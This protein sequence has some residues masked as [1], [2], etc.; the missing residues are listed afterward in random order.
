MDSHQLKHSAR[1][2]IWTVPWY[3]ASILVVCR[4][5]NSGVASFELTLDAICRRVWMMTSNSPNTQ[6]LSPHKSQI[7]EG[8]VRSECSSLSMCSES[9]RFS[10]DK[11]L[12]HEMV[13]ISKGWGHRECGLPKM[14]PIRYD[15]AAHSMNHAYSHGC[16]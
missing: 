14:A 5:R 4:S 12:P 6:T 3:R 16:V 10:S 9:S 2:R 11:N 13:S 7:A 8:S 15:V 1:S